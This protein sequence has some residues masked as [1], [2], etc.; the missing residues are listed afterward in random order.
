MTGPAW[1]PFALQEPLD[2]SDGADYGGTLATS[3]GLVLHVQVGGGDLR[4]YFDQP[5]VQASSHWWVGKLGRLVQYL[6]A[7]RQSWA[8][9]AGNS[10]WHSVETEGQ[11]SEP[12]TDAQVA[13]LGRLYAW[14]HAAWG[15]PL[16]LTDTTTGTGLGWHG[17][18]GAA[19]GGHT[20]CPG[21]IRKAQRA[22]ILAAAGMTTGGDVAT[23]D[24]LRGVLNEGTA[25]GQ[26]DWASTSKATLG[27]AQTDINLDQAEVASLAR[28]EASQARIEA[29][30]GSLS[31]NLSEPP[32]AGQILA[33]LHGL[34]RQDV[35][36]IVAAGAQLLA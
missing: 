8:Q 6:P 10:G 12:L 32:S 27:A 35:A 7:D 26:K 5:G 30:I 21:D 23:G 9:A 36:A 28:V 14:G 1:C 25:Q 4:S 22:A 31:G 18:G 29:F 24:D 15:W 16:H 3:R 17:M 11:P 34:A 2:P 20:G 33:A 13:T 19:W